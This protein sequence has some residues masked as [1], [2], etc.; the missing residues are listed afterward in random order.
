MTQRP[1]SRVRDVTRGLLRDLGLTTVFGNPGSTELGFLTA[2][3][4]D[5]RYVLALQEACAVAMADGYAQYSG[6]A[7]LVNL[8]SI[9]GVGHAMGAIATA[10]RNHT[11][12]VILA[13]QQAR[14]LLT[15]EPFLGSIEATTLVKPYVRWAVE[16]A[17]AADVPTAIQRA[18]L[19]ATTPPYG[20]TVV[21]VPADDWDQP[22][23]SISP[24]PRMDGIAP[25]PERLATAIE[26]LA[27]SQRP[28][29]V[30]GSAVDADGAAATAVNLAETLGAR[31]YAAPMSGRC[32]FPEGHTLFG[33]FP[34]PGETQPR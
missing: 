30:L 24:R 22:G 31:V 12:M 15:G 17:R 21:S 7:S 16:P 4:D 28:A 19:V 18:Y 34:R 5:F 10:Y 1:G 9:G 14:P 6:D 26:A 8:H 27:A 33:G 20:P 32:S 23:L 25:D 3:P 11:P 13:G 29:L 2:W